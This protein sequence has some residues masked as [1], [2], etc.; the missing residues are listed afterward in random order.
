MSR[1][2]MHEKRV[3]CKGYNIKSAWTG[4]KNVAPSFQPPTAKGRAKCA[5]PP[6]LRQ[7]W[8]RKCRLLRFGRG[9]GQTTN[10]GRFV[11]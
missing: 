11:P 5:A 8:R 10:P 7:R 9:R 6:C 3:S 2:K 4:Q 1:K